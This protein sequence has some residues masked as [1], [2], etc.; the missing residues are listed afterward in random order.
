MY[1]SGQVFAITTTMYALSS[2]EQIWTYMHAHKPACVHETCIYLRSKRVHMYHKSLRELLVR[3][4]GPRDL[5][6]GERQL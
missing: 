4:E 3:R 6:V 2:L 5:I 1:E